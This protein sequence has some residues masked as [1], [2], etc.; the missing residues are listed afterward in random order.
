MRVI[1]CGGRDFCDWQ[2]VHRELNNIAP[3]TV[4]EGGAEGA[5]RIARHWAVEHGVTVVTYAA[6]WQAHGRSAGPRR[7]QLMLDHGK[8]DMVLAFPGG[9]GTADMCRRA[10]RAG[11]PVHRSTCTATVKRGEE[12]P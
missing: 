4:L 1:V 8:P 10:R 6:D 2:A 12:R 5:D 9:A 3:T 11:I 7:N